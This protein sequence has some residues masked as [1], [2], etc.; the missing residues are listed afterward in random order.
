M[1]RQLG[2]L[3]RDS[4]VYGV[5]GALNRFAKLLVVPLVAKTFPAAIFGAYDTATVAIYALASLCILG[6]HSSV[7]I[8][9][10]RGGGSASRETMQRP[11]S[12]G[13]R[14]TA[15]VS[16]VLAALLIVANW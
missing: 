4:A 8:I 7:V 12:T 11:A 1:K 3:F 13:L 5:A 14:V 16:L 2:L 15:A 9:A 10:T 6:L